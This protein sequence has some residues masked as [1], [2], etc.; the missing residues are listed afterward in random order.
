M[1]RNW[2][3]AALALAAAAVLVGAVL[4]RAFGGPTEAEGGAGP[5]LRVLAANMK[6]G[7][8]QRGRSSTWCAST[9]STC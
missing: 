2:A 9:T 1:V 6:L 5:T 7:E 8:G 4:P 3:A